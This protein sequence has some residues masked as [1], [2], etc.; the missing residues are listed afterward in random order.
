[1]PD[2]VLSEHIAEVIADRVGIPIHRMLESERE[3]LL[4]MEERIG[5]RVYGQD[6]A[7][8]AVAEAARRMRADCSRTQT[9]FFP[10]R[11][12]DWCGQNRIGQSTGGSFV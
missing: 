4:K 3:R 1:M 2:E 12:P 7:V 11:R 8:K 10:V 6:E 5:E 9:K